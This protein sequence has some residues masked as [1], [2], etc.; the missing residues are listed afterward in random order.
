MGHARLAFCVALV[1]FLFLNVPV[2]AE[3]NLITYVGGAGDLYI[4]QPDGNGRRKIAAGEILQSIAFSPQLA[5]GDVNFY[6]WP[7]WSPD[8]SQLACFYTSTGEDGRTDSLYIFDVATSRVLYS[9]QAPGLQP[10]YAYW[11]PNNRQLAVLL[12]GSG[13]LSLELWPAYEG[14]RPKSLAQGAP[15]YFDWRAD[16]QALLV[17]TGG[18]RESE[19]G[20]SVSLLDIDKGKRTLV[21]RAPSA[22]GP[23]S[24][25][26][27]GKWL[28][29]GN[30]GKEQDKTDLMIATADGTSAKSFGAFSTRITM[31]WSPTQSQLAVA[32][33]PFEAAPLLD[34]LQLVDVSSGKTRMLVQDNLTAYFW[35]PDGKRILYA[36]K[37][38]DSFLWTW[39][40]IEVASGK[41]YDVVDFLPSRPLTM[42]FQYFDQYALSHRL[43]SPD[44][45]HFTFSGSAGQDAH[46]AKAIREPAVYVVDAKPN[47]SPRMLS[48]G[49]I[50]FWSPR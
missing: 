45:Q 19:S 21:S 2:R 43:W 41:T 24:W 7:I 32:S 1:S 16:A 17:H 46:P 6:S 28:A 26:R 35:S 23:P 3:T 9:Y 20:H 34:N 47:A 38:A 5:K 11:S 4:I 25:S 48:E 29:Y 8:G 36:K 33:S 12:G 22:F 40:I 44:S 14:K 27:N 31:E 15:F 49:A 18:D 39:V 37:Q 10:I 50:A 42:V 30:Q 13:L